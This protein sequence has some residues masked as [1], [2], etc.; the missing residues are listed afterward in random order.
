MARPTALAIPVREQSR[1]R[2]GA[3]LTLTE[4][5]GGDL[6]AVC[7]VGLGVTGCDRVHLTELLEVVH[8]DLEAGEVEEDVLQSATVLHWHCTPCWRTK[9]HA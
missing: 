1:Q 6:N 2:A 9:T 7:D 3:E 4:R 8:G 5:S